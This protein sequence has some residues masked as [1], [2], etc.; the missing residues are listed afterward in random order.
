MLRNIIFD[1]GVVLLDLDFKATQ[2]AFETLGF[3]NHSALFGKYS[4]S[5]FFHDFE[6]GKVTPEQ[7]YEEIR[8]F[9]KLPQLSN[10]QIQTAWNAML[11]T[12]PIHRVEYLQNLARQYKLFLFSNTNAIHYQSFTQTFNKQFPQL[13]FNTLFYKPYFSHTLGARK[14]KV[15]SYQLLLQKENLVASQTLFIDDGEANIE[16]AAAAGLNTLLLNQGECITQI[17]PKYLNS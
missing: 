15:S 1:L 16:G 17:L 2:N 14:P 6:E 8:N 10:E 4:G 12:I 9:A 3:A 13:S 5:Q 11:L 7:F